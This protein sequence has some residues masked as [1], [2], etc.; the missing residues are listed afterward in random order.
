MR[1]KKAKAIRKLARVLWEQ[2]PAIKGRFS[3]TRGEAINPYKRFVRSLKK[4]VK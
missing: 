4:V 2:D 1:Q 3:I